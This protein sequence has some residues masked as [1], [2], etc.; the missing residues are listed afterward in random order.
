MTG[1]LP[2]HAGSIL[3][4]AMLSPVVGGHVRTWTDDVSRVWEVEEP[5]R[6][7]DS[8]GRGMVA[9]TEVEAHRYREVGLLDATGVLLLPE[10]RLRDGDAPAR[11]HRLRP[12]QA[13][14][15]VRDQ[16]RDLSTWLGEAAL[17]SARRG[18]FLVV[19]LGGWEHHPHPYALFVCT[20]RDGAWR[21]HL[22]VA[23]APV[24]GRP[25]WPEPPPD[26]AG[27]TLTGPADTGTIAAAGLALTAALAEWPCTPLDLAVTYGAGPD[28]PAPA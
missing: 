24:Q 9:R 23:P 19:E 26:P 8:L 7:A 20:G 16:W 13:A 3:T 5:E 6:L 1:D 2:L 18:E 11:A 28:G 25:P 27:A 21:S 15:D 4:T 12:V 10:R 14:P 17:A 22:E